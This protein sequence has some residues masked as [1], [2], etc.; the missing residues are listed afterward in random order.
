MK[1]KIWN[2]KTSQ[3]N[4]REEREKNVGKIKSTRENGRNKI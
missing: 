1:E 3:F 4:R 2:E